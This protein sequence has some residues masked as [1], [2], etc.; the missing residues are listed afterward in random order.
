MQNNVGTIDRVVRVVLGLGLL[1]LFGVLE[2]NAKFLGLI[3]L[4]PLGTA[5]IRFCPLYRLVGLSTCSECE[6]AAE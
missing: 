3:G 4:I 1:S 5:A 6:A 2:G